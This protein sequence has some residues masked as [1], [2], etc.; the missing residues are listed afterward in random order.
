MRERSPSPPALSPG[1]REINCTST[2]VLWVQGAY[3]LQTAARNTLDRPLAQA[4]AASPGRLAVRNPVSICTRRGS[5][6]PRSIRQEVACCGDEPSP[7]LSCDV[8]KQRLFSIKGDPF[9]FADWETRCF[10]CT[11]SLR[12]T[13]SGPHVPDALALAAIL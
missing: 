10:S 2:R 5:R 8:A 12:R 4:A 11:S 9:L 1:E 7:S 3:G 6:L 13:L